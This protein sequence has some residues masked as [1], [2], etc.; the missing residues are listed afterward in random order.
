M[1]FIVTV[2]NLPHNSKHLEWGRGQYIS[3]NVCVSISNAGGI[4]NTRG[5]ES[6]VLK[7]LHHAGFYLTKG[8]GHNRM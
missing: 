1:E 2:K 8:W 4:E 6:L 7:Y 3:S 5:Y